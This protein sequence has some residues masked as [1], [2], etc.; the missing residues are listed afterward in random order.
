MRITLQK[1]EFSNMFSYGADNIIEFNKDRISQLSAPNGSG[2]TSLALIL[3]EILFNKNIKN[4]KKTD[5][6]NRYITEKFW[7]GCLDFTVDDVPYTIEV[8]RQGA[9]S[10]VKL[11]QEG[12]DISEHKVLDTYKKVS[13]ILGLEYNV[14]SQIT[15]QSSTDLLDFLKATDTNRKKFLINLF[16]LEK[17]VEIGETIKL[18]V[19]NQET[20]V[21][22]L[23]IELNTVESFLNSTSIPEYKT[24]QDVPAID[25]DTILEIADIKKQLTDYSDTCKAIDKNNMLIRERDSLEFDIAMTKPEPFEHMDV[26]QTLKLDIGVLQ[27]EIKRLQSNLASIDTKDKCDSCGQPI[28]NAQQV[29]MQEQLKKTIADKEATREQALVKARQY[30]NEVRRIEAELEAYNTNK[31][32][33]DRFEQLLQLIDESMATEYP[34]TSSLTA[35][36]T[37][38]ENTYNQQR[39]QNTQAIDYNKQVSAHNAKVDALKEQKIEFTSRQKRLKS[40][41]VIKSDRLTSLNILK[42]AFSPVGIVAFKLE[43]L[44]KEL[45]VTIN[46]YLSL[47]SDGQFQL[48]FVLDKEKLNIHIINNGKSAPLETVSAGEFNRIQTA[49]LLAIKSLL[50]KLGGSSV[51]LLFLDEIFGVLD[52]DGKEKLVEVLQ[53]EKELNVFLIAH[54]YSHPLISKITINKENNISYI[55]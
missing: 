12:V 24:E 18:H 29:R 23:K 3:Q 8:R 14:F 32:K 54:D 16:N 42:K 49:I 6:L 37:E 11:L 34:D 17:Y 1:L 30:S 55:E 50:S 22:K 48:E 9:T 38:L 52:D 33:V 31:R 39:R 5:I 19:K 2:K 40:D 45:E 10:K 53:E 15:Y 35:R 51:N 26:Y 20:E 21:N 28:D 27:Q 41:I 46:Y 25:E 36:R 47:L 13:E 4:V 43:N 44:T 7:Q